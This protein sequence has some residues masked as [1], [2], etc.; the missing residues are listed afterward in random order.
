MGVGRSRQGF[1]GFAECLAGED[2]ILIKLYAFYNWVD[3]KL[4]MIGWL[5]MGLLFIM[6]CEFKFLRFMPFWFGLKYAFSLIKLYSEVIELFKFWFNSNKLVI[7]FKII[8][9]IYLIKRIMF[10]LKCK[11]YVVY[12]N[13]NIVKQYILQ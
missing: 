10:V 3:I 6:F 2:W 4:F 8:F 13:L 9:C 12:V 5:R 11:Y 1:K 7:Y